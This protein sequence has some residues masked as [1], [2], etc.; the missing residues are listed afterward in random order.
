[1]S[2]KS[3]QISKDLSLSPSHILNHHFANPAALT[4]IPEVGWGKLYLDCH[5]C[6]HLQHPIQNQTLLTHESHLKKAYL[7]YP[8]QQPTLRGGATPFLKRH[9]SRANSTITTPISNLLRCPP[10]ISRIRQKWHILQ[11]FSLK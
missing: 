9:P 4:N 1:M 7:N 5:L 2:I 11:N 8:T 10:Q 3:I 6:H